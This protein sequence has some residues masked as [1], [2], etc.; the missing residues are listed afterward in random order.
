MATNE[1]RMGNK[2]YELNKG[3]K[4]SEYPA[5]GFWDHADEIKVVQPRFYLGYKKDAAEVAA[6]RIEQLW[7]QVKDNQ[8]VIFASIEMDF[9]TSKLDG[10]PPRPLWSPLTLDMAFAIAK[11]ATTFQVPRR[12]AK[13]RNLDYVKYLADLRRA[14]P[15]IQLEAEEEEAFASGQA[16]ALRNVENARA[17]AKMMEIETGTGQT[18]H[19]AFDDYIAKFEAEERQDDSGWPRTQARQAARLKGAF[20]DCV[21]SSIRFS[22]MQKMFDHWRFRKP[23]SKT[24]GKP[25]AKNTADNHVWQ[26][27]RQPLQVLAPWEARWLPVSLERLPT[28]LVTITSGIPCQ[29]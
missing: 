29:P 26:L 3:W 5:N 23:I 4:A 6:L 14:F 16:E 12:H 11:G 8:H 13:Q 28:P 20:K 27:A 19:Q 1:P 9:G 22:E 25:I 18:L 7:K 21:L 10:K 15:V 2:G 24:T 17:V